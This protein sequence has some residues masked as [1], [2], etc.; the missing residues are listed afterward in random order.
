MRL[1]RRLPRVYSQSGTATLLRL[2]D[3]PSEVREVG[4]GSGSVTLELDCDR[5]FGLAVDDPNIPAALR[6]L[7]PAGAQQLQTC[8]AE[9]D[10]KG[11]STISMEALAVVLLD[12]AER[13]KHHRA[14]FTAPY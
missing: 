13:P 14:R 11:N 9:V 10:A 6:S 3:I 5:L 12:E 4:L 8:R 7:A 1:L 2:C